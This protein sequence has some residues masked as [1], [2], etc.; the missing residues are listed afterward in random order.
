ML[1]EEH[2]LDLRAFLCRVVPRGTDEE[3]KLSSIMTAL[4]G[5]GTRRSTQRHTGI[6]TE[7]QVS[8]S[9]TA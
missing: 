5:Y 7:R 1:T 8:H 6:K 3:A 9:E 4:E 2:I